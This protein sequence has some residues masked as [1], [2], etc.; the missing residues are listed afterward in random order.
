[1]DSSCLTFFINRISLFQSFYHT[2]ALQIHIQ[3]EMSSQEMY[4]PVL[5]GK[6]STPYLNHPKIDR[7]I[8]I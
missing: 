7:Q 6:E 1:M 5:R 2:S 3:T 4:V 8:D